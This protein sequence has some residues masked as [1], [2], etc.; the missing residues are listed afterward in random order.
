MA[1]AVS[2]ESVEVI[3]GGLIGAIDVDGGPTLRQLNVLA[4]ITT[5]LWKRP[6]IDPSTMRGLTV[7]ETAD[8]LKSKSDRRCFH[9]VLI[10]LEVCRHPLTKAQ[11]D[12]VESYS[13][14]LGIGGPDLR[15]FRDLVT[16]GVGSAAQDFG[17]FIAVNLANRQEPSLQVERT[18]TDVAI[19]APE[20]ELVQKLKA[21]Q[22][23]PEGSLGRAF[24]DFYGRHHIPL[25]GDQ[26]N[27][28]N[29]FYVGHDMT[30]VI[31]GIEPTGP[32][33]VALSAFQWAMNDNSVNSGALL[34]SL[35]VHE[36]GFGQAGS[37]VTETGQLG[38]LG[39]ADLLGQEMARGAQ[40]QDDFSLADHF[41]LAGEQLTAVR[42][43]FG[44]QAPVNP[45]DG[46]HHW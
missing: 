2:A 29:H 25:P 6:D 16:A 36:A 33:E 43:L 39:A 8:S 21:F 17:R 44:V 32:G 24:L 9:E 35:V 30:H 19:T 1:V 34:A 12:A 27:S 22:D 20:P 38:E 37:L 41:V 14:A 28:M 46:H 15:I 10:A 4:S 13:L 3:V 18:Q 42:A 31:A 26:A 7:Q 23:L 11:V 40:C 5:H 45:Q